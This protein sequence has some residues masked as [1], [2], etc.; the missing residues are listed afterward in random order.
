MKNDIAS[1][2]VSAGN[3]GRITQLISQSTW[4]M[5]MPHDTDFIITKTIRY[6]TDTVPVRYVK[7]YIK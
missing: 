1:I 5:L 4:F 2:P 3:V 6:M 7:K